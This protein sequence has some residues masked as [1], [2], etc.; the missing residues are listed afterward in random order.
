MSSFSGSDGKPARRV[1]SRGSGIQRSCSCAESELLCAVVLCCRHCVRNRYGFNPGSTLSVS[2]GQS[3]VAG[4]IAIATTLAAASGAIGC[5]AI[6]KASSHSFDLGQTLNGT[7][8]GL[9][10]ITAGCAVVE[11]WAAVVIGLIGAFVYTASSEFIRR[12]LRIDDVV[13]AGAV[14]M[15]CG[16]WGLIAASLFAT[17][18]NYMAAY[19]VQNPVGYGAFYAPR[20]PGHQMFVCSLVGVLVVRALTRARALRCAVHGAEGL[21]CTCIVDTVRDSYH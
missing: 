18:E 2:Y 5:L 11:P 10:S 8:A 14:H 19:K 16:A 1:A 17:K 21:P 15:C 4:K 6:Y 12:K 7:L 13:D 9:V 3:R 20:G